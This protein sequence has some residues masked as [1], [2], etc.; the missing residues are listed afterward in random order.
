M[1]YCSTLVKLC[2]LF[3]WLSSQSRSEPNEVSERTVEIDKYN[4]VL[5]ANTIG[6]S[7]ILS[8]KQIREYS[9][10]KVL[11]E[12]F[13]NVGAKKYQIGN[14]SLI[15]TKNLKLTLPTASTVEHYVKYMLKDKVL[16]L[17]D[18]RD[19][20]S[21]IDDNL[22]NTA[23]FCAHI[24]CPENKSQSITLI[25]SNCSHIPCDTFIIIMQQRRWIFQSMKSTF[26]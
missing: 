22:T 9:C 24:L 14:E 17:I 12:T 11:Y 15:S 10:H 2:A 1:H 6:L 26:L 7:Y 4:L 3:V 25:L 5:L 18:H 13:S 8:P 19:P 21:I 16:R 20:N 23:I